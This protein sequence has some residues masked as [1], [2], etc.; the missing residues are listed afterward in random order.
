M[1][2]TL[3]YNGTKHVQKWVIWRRWSWCNCVFSNNASLLNTKRKLEFI[4][5]WNMHSLKLCR[6]DDNSNRILT[7]ICVLMNN[8][9]NIQSN[10]FL[11]AISV[12]NLNS[13]TVLILPC[14]LGKKCFLQLKSC[15]FWL[16]NSPTVLVT[17]PPV[18]W[19]QWMMPEEVLLFS[20]C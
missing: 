6:K 7:W 9:I 19:T 16:E 3:L 11:F 17:T 8:Y 5:S 14:L 13:R 18:I 15:K 20:M 4:I 10:I 1:L 12:Y 2:L